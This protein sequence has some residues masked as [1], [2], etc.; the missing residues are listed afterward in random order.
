M[1]P[2]RF[3]VAIAS[4]FG[5]FVVYGAHLACGGG[6][7][8]PRGVAQVPAPSA[9]SATTT[10]GPSTSASASPTAAST[11]GAT[12][13]DGCACVAPKTV[14]S[15]ALGGDEKIVL[16]PLDAT[17]HLDVTYTRGA[18]GKKLA[19]VVVVVRAYRSD[20][21]SERPTTL[22]IRA[23]ASET[24]GLV[25]TKDVEAY[26]TSWGSR[27]DLPPRAYATVGK[28][29]LTVTLSADAVEVRGSLTLKD[30]PSGKSVVIDKLSVRKTGPAILPVRSGALVA[31]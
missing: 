27:L 3:S 28:S 26:L 5:S 31:P 22:S 1:A 12:P 29:A 18:G 6:G 10:A 25:A 23:I 17:V 11:T 9:A 20:Q 30:V 4:F 19:S 14:A 16:D 2:R 13:A 24:G 21:P 7:L 15:L 8:V